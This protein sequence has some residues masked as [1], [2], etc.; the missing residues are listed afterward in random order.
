[1]RHPANPTAIVAEARP[2]LRMRRRFAAPRALLWR[3]WS[4][5]EIMVAWMGPVEW[6]AFSV[7]NDFRVGGQW[8]IG[9]KSPETGDELWQGGTYL[10]IAEP[11][12]LVFTFK[13]EG[14]HED[15]VPVD[16]LVTVALDEDMAGGTVM[17]FTHAGLKSQDSLAGHKH[18]WSG[19][20]DRLEAWLA[21][22]P[23]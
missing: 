16:T 22:N 4:R 17:D 11:E 9:L 14:N 5:P 15:G 7:S 2:T 21:A 1:M 3:A 12:R 10:E 8:R 23:D 20:I 19:T 18:G 13:W 6:P